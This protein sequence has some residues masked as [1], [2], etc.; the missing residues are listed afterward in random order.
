[1][2]TFLAGVVTGIVLT[3]IALSVLVVWAG[4]QLE[5]AEREVGDL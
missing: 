1:M 2:L 3:V 5:E 4:V